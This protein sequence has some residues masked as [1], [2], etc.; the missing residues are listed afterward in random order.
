MPRIDNLTIFMCLNLL[1]HFTGIT[2]IQVKDFLMG[3]SEIDH[4]NQ[5]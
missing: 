2:V 4:K 1:E 3:I 5:L